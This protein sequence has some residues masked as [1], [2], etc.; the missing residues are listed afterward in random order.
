MARHAVEA[1]QSLAR[2]DPEDAVAILASELDV[3]VGERRAVTAN[4]AVVDDRVAVVAI[5]PSAGPEPH[6]AAAVLVHRRHPGTGQSVVSGELGELE[7]LR[8]AGTG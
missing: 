3:V 1:A 2:A 8:L 6:E 5:Q 4:V 7:A